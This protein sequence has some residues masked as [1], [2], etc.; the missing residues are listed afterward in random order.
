MVEAEITTVS[1]KGQVVIP[2]VVREQLKLKPK[3]KMLVYGVDDII[4]LKKL[5]VPDVR[6][7]LQ[8]LYKKINERIIKYGELTEEEIA[9]EVQMH[10][11]AKKKIN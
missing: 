1:E 6:K 3:T 10:R 11:K 8:S 4:I 9:E 5:A 7:E 2:Q